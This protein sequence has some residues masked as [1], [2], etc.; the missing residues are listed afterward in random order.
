MTTYRYKV[1]RSRRPDVLTNRIPRQPED[2]MFTG[3]VNGEKASEIEE[4]FARS[5]RKKGKRFDFQIVVNTG[6][7][8]PGQ[9]NTVDFL[10]MDGLMYPLEIDGEIAHKGQAKRDADKLRDAIID[11]IMVPQGWQ[12]IQR[13][14]G[15][16]LQTQDDSDR[17]VE[18]YI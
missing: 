15:G 17:A 2:E 12:H 8:V 10:I 1:R 11:N 9:K 18:R 3:A 16:D 4:R 14:P 13:V 6:F 7:Q 5:L